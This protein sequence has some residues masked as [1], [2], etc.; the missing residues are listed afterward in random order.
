M[1]AFEAMDGAWLL[2]SLAAQP[3]QPANPAERRLGTV[4]VRV[5]P[6]FA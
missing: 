4:L 1:L 3:A 5:M 2:L 6:R